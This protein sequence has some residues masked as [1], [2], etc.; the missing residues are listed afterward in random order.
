[1][2]PHG[3]L[4]TPLKRAR[5]PIP[6][7]RHIFYLIVKFLFCLRGGA[8]AS[9]LCPLLERLSIFLVGRVPLRH[10]FAPEEI[11]DFHVAIVWF[12][13][14]A[15]RNSFG[16]LGFRLLFNCQNYFYDFVAEFP[17]SWIIGNLKTL[18]SVLF[19]YRKT[20]LQRFFGTDAL[21]SLT[22]HYV[23]TKIRFRSTGV[24]SKP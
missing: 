6:P 9:G 15:K 21:T 8:T 7:L 23:L 4:H 3:F 10:I 13:L 20:S 17:L 1:M 22:L 16:N 5:I 14:V 18:Y 12:Q 2:N 11:T 24:G 19:N